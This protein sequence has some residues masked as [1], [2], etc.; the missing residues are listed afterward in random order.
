VTAEGTRVT[1]R[2]VEVLLDEVLAGQPRTADDRF[3]AAARMFRSVT[4]GEDF[5]TFFTVPGYVEHLV[6]AARH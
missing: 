5:P 3:D 1:R 6:E 4:L 2:T